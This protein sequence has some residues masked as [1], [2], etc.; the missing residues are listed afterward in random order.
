MHPNPLHALIAGVGNHRRVIHQLQH[1][2]QA[3]GGVAVVF[4][5]ED[6]PTRLRRLGLGRAR[7]GDCRCGYRGQHHLDLGTLAWPFA[8]HRNRT[9]MHF[10][11]ALDQRQSQAETTL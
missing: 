3:V 8:A 9:A 7:R 10:H 11:Q 2:S 6:A 1:L 4:D 5:D